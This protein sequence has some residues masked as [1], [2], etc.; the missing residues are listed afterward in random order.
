M[1]VALAHDYLTQRGGAERV[2]LA[3]TRIFPGATLHTSV[4]EPS[5]TFAGFAAVDVRTSFL[6]RLPPL[7]RD[8]RVALPLLARAW[9]GTAVTDPAV[10]AVVASSSGWAHAIGV[11]EGCAKVVYCHNPARWLYQTAEYLPSRTAQRVMDR[12]GG[13]LRAWDQRAAA[14]ADVYLANSRIVAARIAHVYG[15]DAEVLPPPVSIDVTGPQ[16]PVEGLEPGFWLTVARG[17]GYKNV[18][19]VIDGVT[20]L[21]DGQLAIVGS[22]AP[23]ASTLVGTGAGAGTRWLGVVSDAQL[24]WLYA[25]ARALVSVSREDFGLTP[26]EANAFGTPVAVLRAGGFLDSLDE[27]TSGVWVEQPTAAAVHDAL[28]AF[29]VLDPV[30]VRRHAARFDEAAFGAR[31]RE[32]A[33]VAASAHR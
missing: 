27:G 25:H 10:E 6:Q 24:R 26:L 4:H 18:D 30:A 13:P 33:A 32:I 16:T 20:A 21:G 29:P 9:D 17:R 31:L 14:T 3:L 8:P 5:R 23:G 1:R 28:R 15:V 7:R 19:A 11:P 12:L 22:P 2:T